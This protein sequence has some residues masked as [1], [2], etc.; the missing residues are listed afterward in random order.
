MLRWNINPL[1]FKI[2]L[3]ISLF[4]GARQGGSL[5]LHGATS[6][7]FTKDKVWG[8]NHCFYLGFVA[9]ASAVVITIDDTD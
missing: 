9:D 5:K 7:P 6:N 8:Q 4:V 2:P 1:P 3:Q